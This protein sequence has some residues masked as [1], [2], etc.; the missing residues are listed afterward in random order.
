MSELL[1]W[2]QNQISCRIESAAECA[3]PQNVLGC[4]MY[5]F[6]KVWNM[7]GMSEKY[8]MKV[9]YYLWNECENEMKVE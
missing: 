9:K 2:M 6:L 8:G 3:Q 5:F 1:K 7:N 4:R